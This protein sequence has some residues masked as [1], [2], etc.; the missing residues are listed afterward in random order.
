MVLYQSA[1]PVT[2]WCPSHHGIAEGSQNILHVKREVTPWS[3]G[4]HRHLEL[5]H[6]SDWRGVLNITSCPWA[7]TCHTL[8]S[9]WSW[10]N[11]YMVFFPFFIEHENMHHKSTETIHL[12][13]VE[14]LNLSMKGMASNVMEKESGWNMEDFSPQTATFRT[15]EELTFLSLSCCGIKLL[16]KLLLLK[17]MA[18]DFLFLESWWSSKI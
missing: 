15:L 7:G 3:L 2:N 14:N 12:W 10:I 18:T 16:H 13:K 17:E 9:V 5:L 6:H 4:K 8:V 1:R 11:T